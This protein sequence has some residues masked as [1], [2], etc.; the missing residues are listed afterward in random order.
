[1]MDLYNHAAESLATEVV[2]IPSTA[3]VV[4]QFDAQTIMGPNGAPYG[5]A[6]LVYS[7]GDV[8]ATAVASADGR[9][10]FLVKAAGQQAGPD[11]VQLGF[12]ID[13]RQVGQA[14]VLAVEASPASYSI[15]VV[16]RQGPHQ[17]GAAFLNDYYVPQ[18]AD[19]NLLL[20][21][22]Q[23]SGPLDLP[24]GKNP[25]H[26]R[27]FSCDPATIGVDACARQILSAFARRAFRRAVTDDEVGR[28]ATL[29]AQAV[30]A[31]DSFEAGVGVAVEAVLS[32][33]HFLFRVERDP[34]P[35]A[36]TP[37]PLTGYE[38]ASRLSYFLWSSMPDDALLAAAGD[39][40]LD[41]AEGVRAQVGRML[42]DPRA[43]ALVQNFAG[44]WLY[45]RGLD[46]H[47]PDPNLFPAW[48]S[49][50]RDAMRAETQSFFRELL[51]GD[52]SI[53]ALLSADWTW[54]NARLAAHYGLP[55]DPARGAV[56]R[57]SLAGTPR[58]GILGHGSVQTVM[59][60]PTR[61]SP[62]R[63]GKW[64]L[65]QIL[66]SAPPPPPPNVPPLPVEQTPTGSLRQ[67][68]EQ[69]RSD[70]RCAGCHAL[71]DP[72]GFAL[73]NFDAIGAFR[74]SDAGFPIDASGDVAS[75][76]HFDGATALSALL[77]QDSRF[78]RCVVQQLFTYALGRAPEIE[79]GDRL[80]AMTAAFEQG[81]GKLKDLLSIIA[82][83]DAFRSRRGQP[84]DPTL[85][86][87]D[88]GAP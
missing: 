80:L 5:N 60:Y 78:H 79:D 36:L 44:Q 70:P 72:L 82:T 52:A 30:A 77:E 24:P 67:R 66:C 16:L 57:L 56:Q 35:T 47:Q 68:L 55:F 29:V 19:R 25:L 88:G 62:T 2:S 39:G 32:S 15:D 49:D 42:A 6:W 22:L 87:A 13:G 28:L 23:L 3:P 54:V 41:T 27:L 69:H 58:R 14:D 31:G 4:Q 65:E 48:T 26:D 84:Y 17:I 46:D 10:T 18:V 1:L 37:H 21:F 7:N 85:S 59:S 73:E 50:L 34:D 64:I 75:L 20:Y 33:P 61:T 12:E 8:T 53:D 11:P 86:P 51:R 40:T 9:Y 74:T 45:T 81:G 76:G 43:D 63:R 83:S 38:L 71:M